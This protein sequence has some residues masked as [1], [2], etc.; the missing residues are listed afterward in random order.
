MTAKEWQTRQVKTVNKCRKQG[1]IEERKEKGKGGRERQ[2]KK[3]GQRL[4]EK[5]KSIS[6]RVID[7]T[8]DTKKDKKAQRERGREK[9]TEKGTKTG[10]FYYS[11]WQAILIRHP[12]LGARSRLS[13]TASRC[14]IMEPK[15]CIQLNIVCIHLPPASG[16]VVS[17][18][19]PPNGLYLIKIGLRQRESVSDL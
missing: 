10:S 9:E 17:R 16:E 1:R 11:E 5:Q 2:R 8:R 19:G 12:R 6:E 14:S 18:K 3:E 15:A 13:Y 7:S 4:R